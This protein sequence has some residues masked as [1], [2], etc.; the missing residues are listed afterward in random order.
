M[1]DFNEVFNKMGIEVIDTAVDDPSS[2]WLLYGLPGSAK[3]SLAMTATKVPEL[4]DVL[5]L[6]LENGARLPLRDWGNKEHCTL[7]NIKS[8]GDMAAVFK[9]IKDTPDSEFPYKTIV[10]DTID[11][12]QDY[13]YAHWSKATPDGFEVW[14][15]VFDRAMDIVDTLHHDTGLTVI[16]ITHAYRQVAEVSGESFIQPYFE[17]KKSDKKM[18]SVFDFLGYM[19]WVDNPDPKADGPVPVLITRTTDAIQSK[20]RVKDFPNALGNPTFEKIMPYLK[21]AEKEEEE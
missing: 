7:L 10:I 2:S 18:A 16:A 19:T 5:Y 17:G 20:R 11:K 6:D 14:R 15:Q 13:I 8:W 21:S 4:Q 1:P 9:W 3:S 12:L